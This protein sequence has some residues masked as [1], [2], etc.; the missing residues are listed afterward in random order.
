MLGI[1]RLRVWGQQADQCGTF[2]STHLSDSSTRSHDTAP[3]RTS[4]GTSADTSTIVEG[5]PPG[6]VP[7]STSTVSSAPIVAE[8]SPTVAHGGEPERFALVEVIAKPNP[9]ASARAM[10]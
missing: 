3:A 1:G 4:D 8:T 5:E 6:V 9:L 2:R 10:G 7:P